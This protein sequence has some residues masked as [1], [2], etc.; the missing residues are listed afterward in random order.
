MIISSK[1]NRNSFGP[2]DTQS[3]GPSY[4]E[5]CNEI[6]AAIGDNL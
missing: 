3:R 1:K 2:R 5:T 6:C 4:N